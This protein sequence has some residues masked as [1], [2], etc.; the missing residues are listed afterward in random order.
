MAS[1]Q[2]APAGALGRSALFAVR[3][4]PMANR[5][6]LNFSSVGLS[7]PCVEAT[8]SARE[9]IAFSPVITNSA[10]TE[11]LAKKGPACRLYTV[12]FSAE[13]FTSGGS[14]VSCLRKLFDAGVRIYHLGDRSGHSRLHAK[15]LL[16]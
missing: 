6:I 7:D 5:P 1:L 4:C 15:I 11:A 16:L 14:E 12:V 13:N 9:V 2:M 10:V 8:S 3:R